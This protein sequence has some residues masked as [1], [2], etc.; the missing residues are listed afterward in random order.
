MSLK[1]VDQ[2]AQWSVPPGAFGR[3]SKIEEMGM[4]EF[5]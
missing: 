4:F 1:H 3:M 2:T 5:E